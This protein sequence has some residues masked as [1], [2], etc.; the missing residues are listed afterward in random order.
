MTDKRIYI[1]TPS[2]YYLDPLSMYGPINAPLPITI[3]AAKSLLYRGI[4]L[5]KYD[6]ETKTSERLT[7][8]NINKPKSLSSNYSNRPM[9]STVV[10]DNTSVIEEG[11]VKSE[12]VSGVPIN[13]KPFDP[14]TLNYDY[15]EDGTIDDNNIPWSNYL[16]VERKAIRAYIEDYNANLLNDNSEDN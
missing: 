7:L 16:K 13:T 5:F 12:V 2:K 15:N 1:T 10:K 6:P 9:T 14:S 4:T 3:S 11:V 8:A